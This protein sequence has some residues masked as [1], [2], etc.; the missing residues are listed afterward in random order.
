TGD[1][2]GP[3]VATLREIVARCDETYCRTI[4]VEFMHLESREERLWL[5][6]RMESTC[7]RVAL[8]PAQQRKILTK[9]TDAEIF[10]QFLHTN[11]LGAKRFSCEGTESMIPLMD[12][13]IEEA[14]RH[15]VEE[16][17]IGMAHRG[18]LNVLA[19]IM[20]KPA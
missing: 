18:R 19:N 1:L 8:A 17:V 20:E 5:Q 16:M 15:G 7:N 2:A 13:L 14:G 11:F 6:E 10:E 9:L 3:E 12:L 4:G